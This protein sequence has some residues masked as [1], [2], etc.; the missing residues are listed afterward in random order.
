MADKLLLRRCFTQ[1]CARPQSDSLPE[2]QLRIG[3]SVDLISEA[4]ESSES[5]GHIKISARLSDSGAAAANLLLT[6]A[7]VGQQS[8]ARKETQT[9]VVARSRAVAAALTTMTVTATTLL[10]LPLYV[11]SAHGPAARQRFRLFRL[12]V[13]RLNDGRC[14]N[15][16]IID[17]RSLRRHTSR[18]S[19]ITGKRKPLAFAG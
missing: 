11:A 7:S 10:L 4:G 2:T 12:A 15:V 13:R 18:N 16:Y 5:S 19:S 17:A 14:R 6:G 8:S 3:R 9:Q 1:R